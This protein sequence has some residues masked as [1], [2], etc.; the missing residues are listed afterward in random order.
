MVAVTPG[1]AGQETLKPLESR[2][3]DVESLPWKP[4]PTPGIDMKILLIDEDTGM[5]TALFRWEPGTELARHEHVEIEQT[6]VLSGSLVD[7]EGEALEG[8]FVWRPAGNRHIARSPNG[9]LVICFFLKPNK[10]L[11]GDLEGQELK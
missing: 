4:T 10:F 8:Q 1:L 7:E 5:M 9:A 2:Y 6:Y 11:D 3:V